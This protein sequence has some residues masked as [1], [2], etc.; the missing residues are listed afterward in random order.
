MALE[1]LHHG[2]HSEATR[3]LQA[4][5][6]RRLKSR[7]LAS[8]AVKEDGHLGVKTL[9]AVRKAAWA[10]GALE[11]TLDTVTKKRVVSAGVQSIIL[12]P[13]KRN[14]RQ[15][16]SAKVRIVK[17]KRDRARLKARAKEHAAQ[18]KNQ[19]GGRSRVVHFAK[20]AAAAYRKQPGAYHYLAGGVANL[21]FLKPS[22]RNYRSDCSQFA[23]SIQKAAGLPDLGSNG[24]LWVNTVIMAHH[25]EYTDH[26]EPGD[27]GMYG[28]RWAPHHV[29]VYCGEPGAEFIGHGSPPI[30]SLTPGRPDFYL[31]NPIK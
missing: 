11:A 29:E 25:L 27:F 1:T 20:E 31:K 22:P 21:I 5:T 10:L 15:R 7:G 8:Y 14:E 13:G 4:A 12:N 28:S 18:A 30:D 19:S 2:T 3:R 6:N 26:P 23:S 16:R 24:P 17:L 9:L